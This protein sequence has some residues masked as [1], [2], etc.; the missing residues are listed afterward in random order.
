MFRQ[1]TWITALGLVTATA[2]AAHEYTVGDLEVIH[3]MAFETAETARVGAGYLEIVN[4]G[5]SADRLVEVRADI[6]R[7]ELHTVEDN[8]GVV[9]MVEMEDGIEVPAGETV[10]LEP[11]GLHIMFMGLEGALVAGSEVP[12]TLVFEEAGEVEVV[13]KIEERDGSVKGHDHGNH[14]DHSH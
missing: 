6:P 7:I 9:K 12:A 10:S 5:D 2:A 14:S 8:D 1:F 4:S 13:F 11:G 3:P